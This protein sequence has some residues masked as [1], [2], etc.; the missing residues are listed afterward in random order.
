MKMNTWWQ[1]PQHCRNTCQTEASC[2][3]LPSPP[4]RALL[5][6]TMQ[7]LLPKAYQPIHWTGNG[8]HWITEVIRAWHDEC[9]QCTGH[10]HSHAEQHGPRGAAEPAD[11]AS[12]MTGLTEDSTDTDFSLSL[13]VSENNRLTATQNS[14]EE[15]SFSLG[16]EVKV[17]I[18]CTRSYDRRHKMQIL[19][20]QSLQKLR[21]W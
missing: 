5:M 8:L 19:W 12:E 4:H 1:F 16:N 2:S 7:S 18:E 6:A 3:E 20:K 21:R 11:A 15:G 14:A 9:C 10:W 13:Q 17:I